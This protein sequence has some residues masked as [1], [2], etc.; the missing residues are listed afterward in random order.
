MSEDRVGRRYPFAIVGIGA[1]PSPDDAWF[2]AVGMVVE[3]AVVDH[4]SAASI[5]SRLPLLPALGSA[6]RI[7]TAKFWSDDWENH[8]FV[9]ADIHDLAAN[10]LPLMRATREANVGG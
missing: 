4:W 10:A 9:F 8:D 7:Q 5:A 3:G 1:T 2:D 6:A